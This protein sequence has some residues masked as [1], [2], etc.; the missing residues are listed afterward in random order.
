M[1]CNEN[2]Y[3]VSGLVPKKQLQKHGMKKKIGLYHSTCEK[4]IW[5]LGDCSFYKILLHS[6]KNANLILGFININKEYRV[7]NFMVSL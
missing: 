5:V 2:K 4:D 1:K 7:G 6:V 3:K